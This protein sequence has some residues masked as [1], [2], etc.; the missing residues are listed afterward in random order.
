MISLNRGKYRLSCDH[1]TEIAYNLVAVASSGEKL[2]KNTISFLNEWLV[3]GKKP[4]KAFIDTWNI[5]LNNY[6][7]NCFPILFRAVDKRKRLNPGRICSYTGSFNIAD[8]YRRSKI[9]VLDTAE[10]M[11]EYTPEALEEKRKLNQERIEFY[12]ENYSEE[13]LVIED[14]FVF[15]FYPLAR[16]LSQHSVHTYWISEDEYVV[17]EPHSATSIWYRQRPQ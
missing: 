13:G 11:K 14:G 3:I 8:E 12:K 10:V 9:I 4:L 7:P 1:K 15:S 16:V 2:S 6:T 5:V 17:R